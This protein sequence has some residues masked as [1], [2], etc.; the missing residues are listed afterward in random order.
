MIGKVSMNRAKET[1]TSSIRLAASSIATCENPLIKSSSLA[2]D[3]QDEC[4]H[5]SAHSACEHLQRLCRELEM[6]QLPH[7]SLTAPLLERKHNAINFFANGNFLQI[8]RCTDDPGFTRD[9]PMFSPFSS[10]KPTTLRCSSGRWRISRTM[11]IPSDPVP[12]TRTRCCLGIRKSVSNRIKRQLSNS[13][14]TV[15]ADNTA[16]PRP[17]LWSGAK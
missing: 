11:E 1:K 2:R 17:K 8:T 9:L 14:S 3:I 4:G 5:R 16:M 15:G 13:K 7:W 10:K 12:T 6:Q